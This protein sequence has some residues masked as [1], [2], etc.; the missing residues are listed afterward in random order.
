MSQTECL[1]RQ[2]YCQDR[3]QHFFEIYKTVVVTVDYRYLLWDLTPNA[4]EDIRLR[5]NF[6]GEPPCEI[7]NMTATL[8]GFYHDLTTPVGLAGKHLLYT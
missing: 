4:P 6:A 7:R 8:R 1:G 3:A 2:L 5:I